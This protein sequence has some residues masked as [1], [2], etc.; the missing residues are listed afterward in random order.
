MFVCQ[1]WSFETGIHIVCHVNV[2]SYVHKWEIAYA[3]P[4]A[5]A[6]L[7]YTLC[8]LCK[9]QLKIVLEKDHF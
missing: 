3:F 6:S 5:Y 1:G 9:Q 4:I 2:C 7:V 8:A